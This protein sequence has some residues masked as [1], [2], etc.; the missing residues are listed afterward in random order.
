MLDRTS[1]VNNITVLSRELWP[2]VQHEK[3]Y[4]SLKWVTWPDEK[5]IRKDLRGDIRN[6]YVRKDL[7]IREKAEYNRADEGIDE[8][9]RIHFGRAPNTDEVSTAKSEKTD[10]ERLPD[11]GENH[12]TDMLDIN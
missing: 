1:V 2:P 12:V 11:V 8:A 4:T 7:E 6:P 5:Q 10:E 9:Q 3:I